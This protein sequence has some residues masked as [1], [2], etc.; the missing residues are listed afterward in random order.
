MR[1]IKSTNDKRPA[2][3]INQPPRLDQ[4]AFAYVQGPTLHIDKNENAGAFT[5]GFATPGRPRPEP[6]KEASTYI[7]KCGGSAKAQ[8]PDQG[9]PDKLLRVDPTFV[10]R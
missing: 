4:V 5:S 7:K 8:P 3:H 9:S 1:V 2:N 10:G 6:A